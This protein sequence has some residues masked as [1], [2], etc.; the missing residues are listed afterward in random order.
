[1]RAI[2][3][4]YDNNLI[5]LALA[6]WLD[7]RDPPRVPVR[8]RACVGG[9]QN[10]CDIGD[11]RYNEWDCPTCE[12][13]GTCLVPDTSYLDR[14]EL[15][16]AQCAL[17][18]RDVRWTRDEVGDLRERV[19]KLREANEALWRSPRACRACA[20]DPRAAA[21][22]LLKCGCPSGTPLLQVGVNPWEP[23][24][25]WYHP[26]RRVPW[27]YPVTFDRGFIQRVMVPRY[28]DLV[29]Y[30]HYD[31]LESVV[32]S[33]LL[34]ALVSAAPESLLVRQVDAYDLMQPR[35]TPR[36]VDPDIARI[37]ARVHGDADDRF[38][39]TGLALVTWART[40]LPQDLS[41]A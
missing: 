34:L 26:E 29:E 39:S 24:A 28:D 12:G 23:W 7:E 16:R 27:L 36:D 9:K 21:N 15:I 38:T 3:A 41:W 25:T 13:T 11:I 8:C 35:V 10:D 1:M 40:F 4:D 2:A 17:C 20:S 32:P 6:D 22:G 5:R 19:V 37:A 30:Y 18:A 31:A 33:A 14:A